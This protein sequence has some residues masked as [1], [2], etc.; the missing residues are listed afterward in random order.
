[1]PRRKPR[2]RRRFHREATGAWVDRLEAR[3]AEEA[4]RSDAALVSR[5]MD[6][7]DSGSGK[8]ADEGGVSASTASS[9]TRRTS[10]A[11]G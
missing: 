1:M 2:S 5:Y 7:R 11:A 4:R 3:I 8:A 6:D 10:S 9:R